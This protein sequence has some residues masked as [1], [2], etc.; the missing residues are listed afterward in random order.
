MKSKDIESA[1]CENSMRSMI[2][3][4]RLNDEFNADKRFLINSSN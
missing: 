1:N 4:N 2:G 3:P